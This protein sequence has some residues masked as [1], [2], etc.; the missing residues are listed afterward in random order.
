MLNATIQKIAAEMLAVAQAAEPV[1]EEALLEAALAELVED[2]R[3]ANE[4]AVKAE[5]RG[6]TRWAEMY[7][8]QE[9]KAVE[10][11]MALGRTAQA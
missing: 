6:W 10:S 4:Q 11:F 8:A 9:T 7:R 3:W 1:S 2:A 5:A